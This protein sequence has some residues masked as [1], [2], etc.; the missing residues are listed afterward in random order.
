MLLFLPEDFGS[1]VQTG[2]F[3]FKEGRNERQ[4]SKDIQELDQASFPNTGSV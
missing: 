3:R 2:P 4:A 1:A